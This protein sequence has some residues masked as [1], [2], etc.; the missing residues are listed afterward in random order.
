MLKLLYLTK[1]VDFLTNVW[2][3]R[4]NLIK[5]YFLIWELNVM[6]KGKIRTGLVIITVIGILVTSFSVFG[7]VYYKLNSITTS[8]INDNESD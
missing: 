5:I 4:F 6:K 1:S 8:S 7:T 3:T 2:Y